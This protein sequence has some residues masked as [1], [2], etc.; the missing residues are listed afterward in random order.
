MEYVSDIFASLEQF[1]SDIVYTFG[2]A[3]IPNSLQT[4]F[5]I[6]WVKHILLN[7]KFYSLAVWEIFLSMAMQKHTAKTSCHEEKNIIPEHPQFK[8]LFA[9]C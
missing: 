3:I 8:S 4:C 2:R 6:F 9:K 5:A 1:L 7:M